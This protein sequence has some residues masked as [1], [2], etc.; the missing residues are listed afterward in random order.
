ML[1]CCCF[2]LFL[3]YSILLFPSFLLNSWACLLSQPLDSRVLTSSSLWLLVQTFSSW[4]WSHLLS[5]RIYQFFTWLWTLWMFHCLCILS[6]VRACVPW[7][8]LLGSGL[9]ILE[10]CFQAS[11]GRS[12]VAFHPSQLGSNSKGSA[13]SPLSISSLKR[14][15]S[16]AEDQNPG[17]QESYLHSGNCSSHNS[18]WLSIKGCALSP[19]AWQWSNCHGLLRT[20]KQISRSPGPQGAPPAA[21]GPRT[22]TLFPKFHSP[23]PISAEPW[24]SSWA[25]PYAA[26]GKIPPG[27]RQSSCFLSLGDHTLMPAIWCFIYFIQLS[28][29][30]QCESKSGTIFPAW[31]KQSS[32]SLKTLSQ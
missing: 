27:T 5:F 31:W 24:L 20:F 10:A 12:T 1:F 4:N 23:L 25:P 30:L 2:V 9:L 28:R 21:P 3:K 14:S 11:W 13:V 15:V 19:V 26:V 8:A 18:W 32:I 16:T 7:A 17:L 22:F 6:H 29:C